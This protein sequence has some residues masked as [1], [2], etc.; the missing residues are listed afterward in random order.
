MQ[1]RNSF[2]PKFRLRKSR[3]FARLRD[4][5]TKLYCTHFLILITPSE[6]SVSR[7]GITVSTKIDKRA[8]VRNK[9]KRRIRDIFRVNR[10]LLRSNF[11]IVIIARKNA[12]DLSF[13]EFK[14]E[15]LGALRYKKYIKKERQEDA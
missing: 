10:S 13:E 14:R 1:H 6:G 3:E 11:D 15:I 8:V 5:S 2:P 12:G 4:N 7:L 9:I